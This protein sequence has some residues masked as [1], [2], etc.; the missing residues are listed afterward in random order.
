MST[1]S[2]ELNWYVNP[3]SK[4]GN[5][6]WVD[7]ISNDTLVVG[8]PGK[9]VNLTVDAGQTYLYNANSNFSLLKTL[10]SPGGEIDGS[11]GFALVSSA[12]EGDLN[13]FSNFVFVGEPARTSPVLAN[14]SYG[15][16]YLY[17][18]NNIST[19][20]NSDVYQTL[21][22]PR[23]AGSNGVRFGC[24]LSLSACAAGA[25]L[26]VGEFNN[27]QT[28]A[29]FRDGGAYFYK[30]AGDGKTFNY[31]SALSF[32]AVTYDDHKANVVKIVDNMIFVGANTATVGTTTQAGAVYYYTYNPSTGAVSGYTALPRNAG[33][34]AA[35][36]RFGSD[37]SMDKNVLAVGAPSDDRYPAA[38]YTGKVF[39]YKRSGSSFSFLQVLTPPSTFNGFPINVNTAFFGD[40]VSVVRDASN[41]NI[42]NILVFCQGF[43]NGLKHR[44]AVFVYRFNLTTNAIT[45]NNIITLT[46]EEL[47]ANPGNRFGY[48]ITTPTNPN[49]DYTIISANFL[50]DD[51]VPGPFTHYA[52]IYN[53]QDFLNTSNPV[54]YTSAVS[55]SPGPYIKNLTTGQISPNTGNNKSLLVNYSDVVSLSAGKV[56]GN[57]DVT[58]AW[59]KNSQVVG[60]GDE[61]FL[62]GVVFSNAG[63]Y[64][65]SAS[66]LVDSGL[67]TDSSQ[68]IYNL[69]VAV[70][71]SPDPG[72]NKILPYSG[73]LSIGG[74][75]SPT[76]RSINQFIKNYNGIG[77]TS[78][79]SLMQREKDYMTPGSYVG[80]EAS[81]VDGNK[82][83]TGVAAESPFTTYL[84]IMSGELEMDRAWSIPV[85][86]GS[87]V[88]YS[89]R[90][91][92]PD[93]SF[94]PTKMSEFYA[95]Y[96]WYS[97]W[98]NLTY[99]SNAGRPGGP[100]G[101]GPN[102]GT[103]TIT[104]VNNMVTN[105]FYAKIKAN[106]GGSIGNGKTTGV[107]YL[108]GP[109]VSFEKVTTGGGAGL[110][111]ASKSYT[112][113]I[114]D[115]NGYG[116]NLNINQL[117]TNYSAT[118]P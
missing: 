7:M 4:F 1:F 110:P 109:T 18:T 25:Y 21:T 99:A 117:R 52:Y 108:A 118:Y 53:G 73:D 115:S 72:N 46:P 75:L 68:N 31:I 51:P 84:S 76:Y 9:T 94:T 105:V 69:T 93:S 114:M 67:L 66:N 81:P 22:S 98:F 14:G 79:S 60:Y 96:K 90:S 48:L 89:W 56:S 55:I 11:Y 45:L 28:G 23:G 44:G 32:P 6:T 37:I 113:F 116:W 33:D 71:G 2:K 78:S 70:Q 16:V 20:S 103:F 88:K 58:F 82:P 87:L 36:D 3:S 43:Y 54:F 34:I 61:L 47:Y 77:D 40:R 92:K 85:D 91:N 100:V 64:S 24:A 12:S 13:G 63:T 26:V 50:A 104:G 42:V 95:A 83:A 17:G 107:W 27:G 41:S 80:S 65:I 5:V 112:L 86:G 74:E 29:A 106:D 15:R 57:P 30:V 97:P 39:L 102:N 111:Q 38:S 62:G 8:L 59:I 10:S 35:Y 19:I 101:P 49:P